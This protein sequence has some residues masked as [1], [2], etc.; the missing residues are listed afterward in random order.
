MM[1]LLLTRVES[2]EVV[3]ARLDLPWDRELKR[4]VGWP[5]AGSKDFNVKVN[6]VFLIVILLMIRVFLG[7]VF[8]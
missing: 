3:H 8:S 7:L 1:I 6:N 2:V 4:L 5:I